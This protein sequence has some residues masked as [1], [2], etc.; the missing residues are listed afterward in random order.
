MKG[1]YHLKLHQNDHFQENG[2]PFEPP[3]EKSN[4]L[5]RRKQRRRSASHKSS[6]CE[7]DQRPFVFVTR[8]VQFLFY[9]NPKFQASSSFLRLYRPVCVRHVRKPHCWFSHEAAHFCRVS[10]ADKHIYTIDHSSLYSHVS[11]PEYGAV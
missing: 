7:A 2:F 8:K 10:F 5:H 1:S 9:L 6:N 4:N 3:H 11:F